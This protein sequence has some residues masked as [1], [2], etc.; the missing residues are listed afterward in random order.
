MIEAGYSERTA[1]SNCSLLKD[2][3]EV[4][5]ARV[6]RAK[7]IDEWK[8]ASKYQELLDCKT[9]RFN[10]RTGEEIELE[11]GAVQL[12]AVNEVRKII[13]PHPG[14]NGNGGSNSVSQSVV[15]LVTS[16]PRPDRSKQNVK[17]IIH[18]AEPLKEQDRRVIAIGKLVGLKLSDCFESEDSQLVTTRLQ[19]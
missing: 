2:R 6:L 19:R 16:C 14:D 13:E 5:L 1:S 3:V 4:S 9:L 15:V 12:G 8:V 18:G 10:P 17:K 7:E 11:A